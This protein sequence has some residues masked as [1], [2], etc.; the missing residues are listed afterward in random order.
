MSR[1]AFSPLAAVCN[2]LAA[3]V[4]YAP[5]LGALVKRRLGA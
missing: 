3:L 1:V 4:G 2:A 5:T